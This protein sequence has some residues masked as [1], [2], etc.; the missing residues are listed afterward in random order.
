MQYTSRASS[1][2]F[3]S[4][5][6]RGRDT[7]VGENKNKYDVRAVAA[8]LQKM[9]CPPADNKEMSK[10]VENEVGYGDRMSGMFKKILHKITCLFCLRLPVWVVICLIGYWYPFSRGLVSTIDIRP[11]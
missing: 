7:T 5:L 8:L 4:L 11:Q 2:C 9:T 10:Q 3:L 6:E 1:G